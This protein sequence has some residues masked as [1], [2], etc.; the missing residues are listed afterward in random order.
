MDTNNNNGIANGYRV[1]ALT[2]CYARLHQPVSTTSPRLTKIRENRSLQRQIDIHL[3][4]ALV[5]VVLGV[6]V[7]GKLML[8]FTAI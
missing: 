2:D 1:R 6:G 3:T 7:L 8:L 5:V 4:I